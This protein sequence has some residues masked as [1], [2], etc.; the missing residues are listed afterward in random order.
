M[1]NILFF[2]LC[3]V[4]CSASHR[5]IYSPKQ[6]LDLE[7]QL[8]LVNKSPVKSI[9]TNFGDMV[10]CIDIKKQPAFNHPLL[11]NHKLQRK[12]SSQKSFGKTRAKNLYTE[13]I[14]GLGKEECPTGTVPIRR[15]TKDNLIRDKPLLDNHILTQNQPGNHYAEAYMLPFLGPYYA[16]S[17]NNSI[18]NPTLQMK[19]QISASHLFLQN[20]P[21]GSTEKIVAGWHV[22]PQFY[23]GDSATYIYA[24]WSVSLKPCFISSIFNSEIKKTGCYNIQCPGFVQ[25]NKYKYLG[26]RVNN[27]SIYGGTMIETKISIFQDVST[28]NW[29]L[30]IE[31][32]PVGYFPIALFSNLTSADKVGYVSF[33]NG[34]RRDFGPDDV[35]TFSDNTD[36]FGVEYYGNQ[37][38]EV[39]YSLQFGGPGGNCG[40]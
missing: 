2:L 34:L 3:L 38:G 1:M 14:F 5:R 19:D 25:T 30:S 32:D 26:F 37:K 18:Y 33:Q 13:S 20:G 28:K 36:C 17:G 11:K 6:D 12:P 21:K 40:D 8:K 24:S 22:A 9:H 23:G 10:D 7:R 4:P 35:K 39:G 29:W 31:N 16:V 27:T 15:T